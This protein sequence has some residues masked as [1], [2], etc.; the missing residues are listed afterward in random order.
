[1]RTPAYVLPLLFLALLAACGKSPE[2]RMASAIASAASGTDVS[3]AKD[4]ERVVLGSGDD[5][6]ENGFGS[7][8]AT[9]A[10][11]CG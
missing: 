4:G 3:V 11:M 8:T 1:M 5:K 9:G 2:E 10:L 7:H 6:G